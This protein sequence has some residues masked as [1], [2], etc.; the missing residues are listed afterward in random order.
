LDNSCIID[1][2]CHFIANDSIIL[3]AGF[4]TISGSKFLAR[5]NSSPCSYNPPSALI[6]LP[7]DIS[8]FKSNDNN[9][10]FTVFPNSNKGIFY[11][12]T[13]LL[14]LD[15][16]T[17]EILNV[18][19]EPVYRKETTGNNIIQINISTF[20]EGIYFIRINYG[21]NINVI[22]VCIQRY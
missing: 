22:P 15:N 8:K 2:K 9:F 7:L 3:K 21:K 17:I 16:Y 6:G 1:G 5:I 4:H 18:I 19:G 10:D 11:I 12:K 13:T 20:T 14:N